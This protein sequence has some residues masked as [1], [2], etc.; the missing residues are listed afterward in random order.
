MP[1][2]HQAR[3]PQFA[4]LIA[5]NDCAATIAQRTTVQRELLSTVAAVLGLIENGCVARTQVVLPYYEYAACMSD[6]YTILTFKGVLFTS[7]HLHGLGPLAARQTRV[8]HDHLA[9]D[10]VSYPPIIVVNIRGSEA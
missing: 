2:A 9:G 5:K 8:L 6:N 3:F 4:R 7:V 1:H 10:L